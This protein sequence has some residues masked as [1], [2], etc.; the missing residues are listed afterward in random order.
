MTNETPSAGNT[1]GLPEYLQDMQDRASRL[2][3]IMNA[4]AF[5]ENEGRCEEGRVAL[6]YLAEELAAQLN[7][8][9]DSVNLPKGELS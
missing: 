9:L 8:A 4:I 6:V 5:L 3:G 1:P 2:S 7:T